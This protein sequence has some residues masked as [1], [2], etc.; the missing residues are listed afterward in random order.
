M[1]LMKKVRKMLLAILLLGGSLLVGLISFSNADAVTLDT[2]PTM[3]KKWRDEYEQNATSSNMISV[4]LT[5]DGGY[6]I[7]GL[8]R[9]Q[10]WQDQDGIIIKYNAND[11]IMWQ[12]SWGG[13]GFDNF[14]DVV[15]IEENG[16]VYYL[17]VGTFSN[18]VTAGGTTITSA[19]GTDIAIVKI[20]SQG[21][22]VWQKSWGGTSNESASSV[23]VNNDGSFVV[24]GDSWSNDIPAS[25]AGAA[26]SGYAPHVIA[27]KYDS[28][29]TVIWQKAFSGTYP[30]VSSIDA[31]PHGGYI[32]SGGT[33]PGKAFLLLIDENGDQIRWIGRGPN[34]SYFLDV[35]ATDTEIIA[36]IVESRG[37][38]YE[39][40]M[41]EHHILEYTQDGTIIKE[42]ETPVQYDSIQP[43]LDSSDGVTVTGYLVAGDHKVAKYDVNGNVVFEHSYDASFVDAFP[44]DDG[45]YLAF[46]TFSG[47]IPA[48]GTAE[49]IS[50]SLSQDSAIARFAPETALY[51]VEVK[52]V[53]PRSGSIIS[54]AQD[55]VAENGSISRPANPSDYT[56]Y[57]FVDWYEKDEHGDFLAE[58]FD[59]SAPISDD[60]VIYS[61]YE[62][63]NYT[64]P[65]YVVQYT[66][67]ETTD[68]A[69][70]SS[71]TVQIDDTVTLPQLSLPEGYDFINWYAGN[72]TD[73]EMV[74]NTS[75]PFSNSFVYDTSE[76]NAAYDFIYA[77][78]AQRSYSVNYNFINN[79]GWEY[80]SYARSGSQTVFHGD[81]FEVGN[82]VSSDNRC[83]LTNIRASTTQDGQYNGFEPTTPITGDLYIMGEWESQY[84][85][86]R[87]NQ[88][89]Y[90]NG[91]AFNPA[92]ANNAIVWDETTN[93]LFMNDYDEEDFLPVRIE[94]GDEPVTITPHG[95][96]SVRVDATSP[97]ILDGDGVIDRH[98][99]SS[100]SIVIENG[101]YDDDIVA[102][103]NLVM[104][105]GKAYKLQVNQSSSEMINMVINGGKVRKVQVGSGAS[106]GHGTLTVNDGEIIGGIKMIAEIENNVIVN[107]GKINTLVIESGG[108]VL[109]AN[110][111]IMNGGNVRVGGIV[112]VNH[113]EM[114]NGTLEIIRS[115][116]GNDDAALEIDEGFAVFNGGKV[117]ISGGYV[118]MV[119]MPPEEFAEYEAMIASVGNLGQEEIIQMCN[120]EP[121]DTINMYIASSGYSFTD[122]EDCVARLKEIYPDI[123][124]SQF[125]DYFG[126]YPENGEIVV[127][128]GGDITFEIA[129]TDTLKDHYLRS[130]IEGIQ[131]DLE[132][133]KEQ[134]IREVMSLTPEEIATGCE[135]SLD[136][137]NNELSQFNIAQFTSVEDCKQ[138]I[139][140]RYS[141]LQ[142]K[143]MEMEYENYVQQI[144]EEFET[145]GRAEIEESVSK[146]MPVPILVAINDNW[147]YVE[148]SSAIYVADDMKKDPTNLV[149]VTVAVSV[150]G[151]TTYAAT[152]GDGEGEA[153]LEVQLDDDGDP[154]GWS[155]KHIP[156]VARL[157]EDKPPVPDTD[158]GDENTPGAGNQG[159][160]SIGKSAAVSS[161]ISAAFIICISGIAFVLY[162]RLSKK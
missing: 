23:V 92:D 46:G 74:F 73:G 36:T 93:T 101:I 3:Q 113:F 91:A 157:Y 27:V 156:K 115:E 110:T 138:N 2:Q 59:F 89:T 48:S 62:K 41:E 76:I 55:M 127:F 58:A 131:A 104:N 19:G 86:V 43:I 112:N 50:T 161:S 100:S 78:L 7:A 31:N 69:E 97:L 38:T 52:T 79:C 4:N 35:Y 144:E 96:N 42:I 122:V 123:M 158:G 33:E 146:S 121:I 90:S 12:L 8:T 159:F 126:Y 152:F 88:L 137:I 54:T 72:I 34:E 60:V 22:V 148:A 132:D 32:I 56:G 75:K 61:K 16:T 20:D 11:Q 114:N 51:S 6:I 9:G 24:G 18:S 63:I 65:F 77:K 141:T 155:S 125:R 150:A 21:E 103:D 116:F 10:Q 149:P 28:T 57:R 98:I 107:N 49:E 25:G 134:L 142:I 45:S 153:E 128:N 39:W 140:E 109:N 40:N 26:I 14:N 67:N 94:N 5:S 124:K 119:A 145:E 15:E 108:P 44:L 71:Q 30:S 47:T 154:V 106:Y 84:L 147:D 82:S 99:Y 29:G 135:S 85:V 117:L 68:V 1:P 162:K 95:N 64:I 83:V 80:D 136:Y 37:G 102:T 53:D 17:A 70:N 130:I 66:G 111:F 87:N 160:L 105:N 120:S 118:P 133:Y 129:N 151:N 13:S 81:I 139:K 143:Q